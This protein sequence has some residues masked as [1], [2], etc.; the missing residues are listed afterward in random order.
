MRLDQGSRTAKIQRVGFPATP[1]FLLLA[2]V[3]ILSRRYLRSG[4]PVLFASST[5]RGLARSATRTGADPPLIVLA[6]SSIPKASQVRASLARS[7]AFRIVRLFAFRAVPHE[8]LYRPS[9]RQ[10]SKAQL[11][12]FSAFSHRR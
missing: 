4:F 5:L 10:I 2:P 1:A 11:E 12:R 6:T 3:G 9:I 7:S 8:S